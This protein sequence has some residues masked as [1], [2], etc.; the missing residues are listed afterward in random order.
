VSN[1]GALVQ[2][3]P[4][5]EGE[6]KAMLPKAAKVTRGVMVRGKA[7]AEGAVLPIAER[8]KDQNEISP[9]EYAELKHTNYVVAHEAPDI[10]VAATTEMP[11]GKA[12][13]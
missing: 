8:P 12:K 3:A 6:D 7:H 5:L 9:L 1:S 11:A 10:T 4:L 2:G 13:P